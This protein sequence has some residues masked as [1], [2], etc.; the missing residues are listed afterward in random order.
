MTTLPHLKSLWDKSVG[1]PDVC[2]AVLDGPVDQ[3]HPCFDGANL[4]WLP[5]L[6]SGVADRGSASQHGTHVASII[7]GQHDS[8][9]HGIAPHCRGLIVPVFTNGREGELAPCSQIDLARAITQAVEQGANVINISGGQLAASAESDKLLE[10]A[11][12]LCQENNVLIVAAVGN[13]GCECLHVPAALESVLAVGAMDAQ[14]NPIGF[15]NWG[16]VYQNQG[17]LA[18]GENVLGAI[19]GG[20]TA[21]KTGTSFATPIVSGIV[22][23]LLSIQVQRGENPDPH[24]IR[25]AILESALPCNQAKGL[26]SRR[27]LVGTLNIPGA[28]ALITKGEIK[29]VSNEKL[30]NVM[31]QPS[32]A[33][34]MNPQLQPSEMFNLSLEQSMPQ[35]LTT[36]VQ[37]VA[38][39][40]CAT[41]GGKSE[42]SEGSEA[43]Q[44]PQ[45]PLAYVL[46]ELGTDF[47]TQ[48][49]QDSFMQAIPA[50]MNLLDYLEQNPWAAQSLIWTV[51]LDTTPIYAIVPMGAYANVVYE[52]LRAFL[53]DENIERVSIPGYVRGSIKLLSG[54]TVP[55]IVPDVRGMYGWSVAALIE[56]LTQA[57][58]AGPSEENYRNKIREYLE[59]IYYE[60]RNL[61]VT[62]QERALNFS[63]TNAFQIAEVMSTGTANDIGL[64]TITVEKSPI[65][66]PDSDCYDVKLQFFN[67]QDSRRAGKVYRFTVDVSDVI[68]VSIGRVRSW[69]IA[70]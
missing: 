70:S 42:A 6:V 9:V 18:L 53:R 40:E 33:D 21:A 69:S 2:V 34:N 41:C 29:Q 31:M 27:C 44:I 37:T 46:G 13:D 50:G 22:A 4:T 5:T 49:R 20:G 59:R 10:N 57:Y 66:R 7:F 28:Y 68:P 63:A 43:K 55:V 65:C 19:P 56:N 48:A 39:S 16:E 58:P 25:D 14:G 1:V 3:S 51:N 26:D 64:D 11:V 24:A 36:G 23:L 32:D 67:L 45:I 54:Q 52:R 15:S 38:P 60:F 47:G 17:I 62:P 8:P 35:P 61:G 12:R 30:E